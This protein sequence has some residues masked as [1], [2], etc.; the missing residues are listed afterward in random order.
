MQTQYKY[1]YMEL[2]SWSATS[3]EKQ[4]CG[5]VLLSQARIWKG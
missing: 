2:Y 3:S 5:E 1:F 4:D